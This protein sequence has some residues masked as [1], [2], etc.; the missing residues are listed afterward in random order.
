MEFIF[1]FACVFASFIWA[2][3]HSCCTNSIW[4]K[5]FSEK[6]DILKHARALWFIACILCIIAMSNAFIPVF[7]TWV[8]INGIIQECEGVR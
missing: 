8:G 1:L 6:I 7:G 2:S 4:R 3:Y 5:D